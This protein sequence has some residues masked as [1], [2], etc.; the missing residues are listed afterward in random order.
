MHPSTIAQ[1]ESQLAYF[2]LAQQQRALAEVALGLVHCE[3]GQVQRAMQLYESA[4]RHL[5]P[6]P[7][8]ALEIGKLLLLTG[9][10]APVVPFLEAALMDDKTRTAAHVHLG[11]FYQRQGS[12]K[13][14]H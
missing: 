10:D 9:T 13:N 2:K 3:C 11:Q 5:G 14:G 8:S 7:E 6:H 12:A 4:T 1:L